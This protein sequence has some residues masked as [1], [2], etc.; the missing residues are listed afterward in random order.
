MVNTPVDINQVKQSAASGHFRSIALWLNYPLVPQA[1][2]ARVQ[3]DPSPGYL[4]VLLEFERPPKKDALI[5]LVCNRLCRL[6]SDLIRG[7]TLI[8]RP[9][10]TDRPL[11]QQR[12]KLISKPT[13]KQGTARPATPPVSVPP[14]PPEEPLETTP[15]ASSAPKATPTAATTTEQ[16]VYRET[17]NSESEAITTTT[18]GS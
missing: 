9:V 10:G 5:R 16:R 8:G 17:V 18:Y 4:Q 3:T 7:V 15:A 14:A 11:W 12:I 6:E 13:P 2:Y 1:I